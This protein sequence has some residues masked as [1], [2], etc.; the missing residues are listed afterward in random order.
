MTVAFAAK[1]LLSDDLQNAP[2]NLNDMFND[3]VEG[4]M[5]FPLNIPGTAHHKCLKV[6]TKA[7]ITHVCV[8]VW[9][10]G[11]L[12]KKFS[13]IQKIG[14]LGEHTFP[15]AIMIYDSYLTCQ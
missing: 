10:E 8:S 15:C 13:F 1:Q 9:P 2:L 5:S 11:V 6:N 4:L 7:N 3:L 14:N 12:L